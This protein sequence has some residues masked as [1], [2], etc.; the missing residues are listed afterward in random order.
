MVDK[1]KDDQIS[2][3]TAL[4]AT[5]LLML[6]VGPCAYVAMNMEPVRQS[7]REQ[8]IRQISDNNNIP[9]DE[10]RRAMNSIEGRSPNY[11]D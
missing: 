1:P 3:V 7:P 8:G 6:F 5:P 9:I 10:V 4:I 2:W 11:R